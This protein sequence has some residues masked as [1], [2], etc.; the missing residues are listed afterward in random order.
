MV[1]VAEMTEVTTNPAGQTVFGPE[2]TGEVLFFLKQ[3][4]VQIYKLNV[5]GKKLVM[6]DIKPESF[7]GEIFT[8]GQGT[9]DN[10]AE[11]TEDSV[12]CAIKR[13]DVYALL[14]A[15]PEIAL[16]VIDH[17]AE[18][19]R[20]SEAQLETLAHE[21][22]DSRLALVLLRECDPSDHVVRDPSQRDLAKR[23]GATC[24]SVTRLLNQMARDGIVKIGPRK[25][26]LLDPER[27]CRPV[28]QSSDEAQQQR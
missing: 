14:E 10:Y 5:D 6:H 12:I 21:R 26:T 19:V 17:L 8:L 22:L 2:N 25:I 23:V 9:A 3:G 15:Q 16:L 24:E 1:R 28:E 4:R 27:V 13:T 20:R 7:F 11:S 18:R